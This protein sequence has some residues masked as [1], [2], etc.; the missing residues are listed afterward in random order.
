MELSTQD[1]LNIQDGIKIAVRTILRQSIDDVALKQ[2][3]A[4]MVITL[5]RV[6]A[7]IKRRSQTQPRA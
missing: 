4:D 6:Q 3:P 1:L 7:E 5:F 2:R